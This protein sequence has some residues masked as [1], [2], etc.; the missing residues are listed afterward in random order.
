M[1]QSDAISPDDRLFAIL[2][3]LLTPI[4]GIIV[5]LI[6]DYKNRPY[7]RYHAVQSIGFGVAVIAFTIVFTVVYLI[8][9]AVTF[10]IL[11]LCLWIFYFAPLIPAIYYAYQASQ[12]RYFEIPGITNFMIQQGWLSRPPTTAV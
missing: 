6:E 5:L 11:G 7:A 10:G 2:S 9:T 1:V 4:V 12:N 3:Y 8:L